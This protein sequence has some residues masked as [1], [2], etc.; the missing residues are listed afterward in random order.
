VTEDER[1]IPEPL[2]TN[3]Y[4]LHDLRLLFDVPPEVLATIAANTKA[5][6]YSTL[7]EAQA[8]DLANRFG[9]QSED[10]ERLA[11]TLLYLKGRLID[12]GQEPMALVAESRD[13]LNQDDLARGRE[14]EISRVI[15][16]SSREQQEALT[17]RAFTNGPAFV[18]AR[19]LPCLLPATPSGTG[20]VGGYLWTITHADAD[21]NQRSITIGITP[22]EL[23]QLETTIEQ[24]KERLGRMW[25][26]I[27]SPQTPEGQAEGS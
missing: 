11:A 16:Y 18:S 8:K 10:L 7:S 21:G 19:F 15:S 4:F 5:Y 13:V 2:R 1:L 14:D 25:D 27:T 23:E 3:E 22:G 26:S 9:M 6:P 17:I 12:I 24:A 20:L